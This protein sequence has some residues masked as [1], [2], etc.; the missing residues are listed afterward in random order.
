MSSGV[1]QIMGYLELL[2]ACMGRGHISLPHKILVT[3]TINGDYNTNPFRI[4]EKADVK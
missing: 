2:T 1:K 4:I 3:L